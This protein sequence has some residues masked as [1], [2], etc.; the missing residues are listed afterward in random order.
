MEAQLAQT[1][2][3]LQ[4]LEAELQAYQKSCLLHLAQ[5]SWVGRIIRSQTGSVEV[6]SSSGPLPF[7]SSAFLS[8]P[9]WT[10]REAISLHLSRCLF[11]LLASEG[12]FWPTAPFT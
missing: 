3:K 7:S 6:S 4:Q 11:G 2:D 9:P 1:T 5:S 8:N 10:S 12:I